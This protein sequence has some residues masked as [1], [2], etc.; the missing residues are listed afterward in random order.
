[1]RRLVSHLAL[2]PS[3]VAMTIAIAT[4]DS[5]PA[6]TLA[7]L[8][9]FG[10]GD[11]PGDGDRA[12]GEVLPGD[13]AGTANESGF[14]K[15]LGSDTNLERGMAYNPATGNLLFLSRVGGTAPDS[16]DHGLRILDGT[17]GVDLGFMDFDN[18]IVTGGTFDR[19]MIAVAD[20][21][22]IYMANLTTNATTSPF[23]IYRWASEDQLLT[24]PTLVYSGAPLAGAR[25]G[26]TLDAIGSGND[27]RL[28][29]GYGNNP[30]VPGNNSFA[31]FTTSDMGASFSATHVEV[32]GT[33]PDAG[34]FRLGITFT[35][36]DT[37]IGK[38]ST[39][40][41]MVDFTG[42][43]GTLAASIG[44]DGASLRPLDFAVVDGRPLLVTL[45]AS[46]GNALEPGNPSA[47]RARI[48]VYDISDPTASVADMKIA[49]GSVF[50]EGIYQ[51]ANING[52]GSVKFGAIDGN[53]VVIYA[54]STNNGIQAFELTL[55]PV[56]I[57]N[58][59]FDGE[60]GVDGADF[61]TWQRNFP[62]T[63]GTA[64]R[65]DG[66]A[67]GDRNVDEADLAVWQIQYGT[68]PAAAPA[69]G[70][71]PEPTSAA[72]VAAA[73]C[74]LAWRQRRRRG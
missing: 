12:P 57:D 45:E 35:D 28:A 6:A 19:N 49:E 24:N 44:S 59:D 46:A 71:V 20:D 14:Y 18:T 10:V 62:V 55:D 17:T 42:G 69:I 30:S 58:A 13:A 41:R 33:P 47:N 4:S 29:A 5:A 70:A 15:Y 37:V 53:K 1:M 66:D 72:L 16:T 52:T 51:N 60:N 8:L 23:K 56:V 74:G 3:C 54:L 32:A 31:V 63:D 2:L 27:T 40:A 43:T 73:C 34:D 38:Q 68:S 65:I 64:D 26:D 25:L 36:A 67:N 21:G 7:P 48:F 11:V 22:A 9:S 50:P 39:F 61:L